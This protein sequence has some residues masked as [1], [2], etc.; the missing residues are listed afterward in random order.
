MAELTFMGELDLFLFGHGRHNRIFDHLGS[1]VGTMDGS[2][3]TRFALWAPHAKS[4][5]VFGDMNFWDPSTAYYLNPEGDSG[6]WQGFMVGVGPGQRYKYRIETQWG[7]VVER[8][9]PYARQSAEPP[10]SGSV[11]PYD[12][13]YDFQDDGWMSTRPTY[14]GDKAISIYE[15]HL[16]SIARDPSDPSRHLTF[17]ELADF[18]LPHII[19]TGFTHVELMPINE[20][21]F[22]GSWGYQTTSLYAPT[23]R[24][25]TQDELREFIDRF[26]QA[27]IGV[28]ADWVP[29]H[30]P[31][32]EFALANFDGYS[33]YE[34]DDPKMASHGDWGTLVFDYSKPQVRNFL[35]GSALYLIEEFH[36]DGLRVDAVASMLYLDYSRNDYTPNIFGGNEDLDAIEF[37][38]Y[39]NEM[40]HQIGATTI[41]EESTAFAKVSKPTY[42]G[43]LGFGF[44]WNMGWMH[45]TLAYLTRDPMYR[46]YHHGEIT[47]GLH[48]AFSENFVLPLSHDEVVHGKGSLYSKFAGDQE[49]KVAT[50]RAL[51]GWMWA[52]PG[53]KMLFMGDEF[54]QISEWAHDQSLDW[55]LL[56]NPVH[57]GIATLVSDLNRIYKSH[58]EL[59]QGDSNPASFSW[60]RANDADKNLF[61]TARFSLSGTLI[62]VA[63]FSG[64][65]YDSIAI[66]LPE[67]GEYE[68]IL[69]TDAT[70]Y[71][72]RGVE[73]PRKIV[74][75]PNEC[76][77]FSDSTSI[78][79]GANSVVWLYLKK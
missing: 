42:D 11:I 37:L 19:E 67:A 12:S 29:A 75:R 36:L 4:V 76:D 33:L 49:T 64:W 38:K 45:D 28:I 13:N 46:S 15:L 32:D 16:G 14:L 63:N 24:F 71:Q 68:V 72:G 17:R 18:L 10:S 50:I 3:G 41:A 59:Y 27:G 21:P 79:V 30:F 77:G 5:A 78:S 22:Y 61:I 55:H 1:R 73:N 25:G 9:D 20:H 56:D 60:I 35:L 70:K 52:H 48:Y 8:V 26:H 66:G 34:K 2:F 53:K 47:F 43:G 74:S 58:P 23:T 44:K 54:G 51:Y 40:V 62:C 31:R 65:R 6:I 7:G 69:N 39:F 57:K